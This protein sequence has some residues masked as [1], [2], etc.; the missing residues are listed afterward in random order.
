MNL[1][2]IDW[3][4]RDVNG[5]T[6]RDDEVIGMVKTVILTPVMIS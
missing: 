2:P 4:F 6:Y 3:K 1:Y 5:C